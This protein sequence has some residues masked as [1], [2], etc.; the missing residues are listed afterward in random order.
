MLFEIEAV[1]ALPAWTWPA[2]GIS[3]MP[4][5]LAASAP[6]ACQTGR[7]VCVWPI[8][9]ISDAAIKPTSA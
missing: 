6:L 7:N 5:G 8:A 1:A 9:A 2:R 3:I 4:A